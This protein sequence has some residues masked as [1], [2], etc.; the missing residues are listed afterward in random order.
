MAS[1]PARSAMVRETFRILKSG[2]HFSISDIVLEGDLPE[3]LIADAEMYAGCVS[4]ALQTKNYLDTIRSSGFRELKILKK[5][6]LDLPEEL[7]DRYAASELM[8]K[9]EGPGI[10]SITVTAKKP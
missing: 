8:N 10:F 7:L 2:G 9:P 3:A 1:D 5:R 6:R 4:G